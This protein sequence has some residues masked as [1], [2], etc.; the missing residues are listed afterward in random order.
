MLL[1]A[2]N[3]TI[4][5]D[6]KPLEMPKATAAIGYVKAPV[7]VESK[8]LTVEKTSEGTSWGAVY[9]QF[10]QPTKSVA[11]Q[12]S[13]LK[14]T[15]EIISDPQPSNTYKV[16][17]RVTVR[18]II[19]AD[20]DYDFVQ[21]IDKRAACLEPVNQLSGYYRGSYCTPRDYSTNFYFD[22]MS[23]G[24][25]VIEREYYI[26]RPGVYE[27]GTCTVQCAYAPEFHGT[28]HSQTLTVKP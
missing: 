26:D 11:D 17:D 9:A 24:K 18:I 20:R 2:D 22:M 23:K 14:V 1:D 3:A 19:E 6:A 10:T 12:S 15:R 16:G 21:V 4:T 7:P 28:T 25:H 8:S 27:T 5:V 13:G